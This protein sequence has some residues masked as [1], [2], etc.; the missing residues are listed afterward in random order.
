MRTPLLLLLASILASPALGAP[1]WKIADAPLRTPWADQVDPAKVLPEY[2]RPQMVRDRW[3]SLNGVWEFQEA[4]PTDALPSG[5]T[6]T[7]SIL[8]PFPWESALSGIRRQLASQRA[9]YRRTFEVP[10]AWRAESQR[11][12]LHFEAV[13][14]EATVFVNGRFAGQHHGGYDP[15]SFDI[16]PHL[17]P[18]GPQELIVTV[19]DPGNEQGIAAGKQANARFA[20][21]QRYSYAPSSGIW[22]PVWLEPVPSRYL[23]DYHVVP[24]IDSGR[25]EVTASP[26][27]QDGNLSVEVVARHG[28][29]VV[30][31]ASGSPN[32][33]ISVA[34]P[35]PRL[36][37]PHD[38]F[39]YD[40]DVVLQKGGVEVDR[41][42]GY[43][44][45]RKIA[46]GAAR[47]NSRG[48]V[49]K[50]FLNHRFMFQMGPLDQGFWP[51]GLH[52][53]PTDAALRW[54]VEGIKAWGFNMVRK[55]IKVESRRWFYHC[56]RAGLLV[57]QDMPSTFKQRTLEE[58]AQFEI[59]LARM[60]RTHWNHPSVVNWVVFNEHW[61]AYDVERLTN[62]VMALDPSRL[63]TGN[64]GI[65]AGKPH[66]DYQVGHI[67]DNHH[68]R[69]PTYPFAT[70]SRAA[71]NGEYGAIGYLVDGHVWDRDGPWVHY[72]YKGKED[73]TAEY[74]KFAA[75]LREFK[76][77]Q[78]L[79]GAVY[80]QWTDVENEM[81]GLHTYDRKVEKLDRARV[82]AA[83]RA[84]WVD[85][86]ASAPRSANTP[87]A[88]P[89][90]GGSEQTPDEGRK[91]R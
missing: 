52:T 79:S 64:S 28:A 72:N 48:P 27:A 50:L 26:D 1:P 75:Q 89:T 63:V 4:R 44:G 57:W 90:D 55:H 37:W 43:F 8:V 18:N 73:A 56:D 34:V 68:Y 33:P 24:D 82:T 71:V 41:V 29:Q 74:E 12:L 13:D 14:W 69:P 87:S 42:T 47:V 30:G 84:L 20:D 85:D 38:P 78:M 70:S 91:K 40:L 3:I 51:D 6:L 31:R 22:L 58:K 54:D 80:T 81:N 11:L 25:I 2:P 5:R 10:A 39:L 76:N 19:F 21:P 77:V 9:H 88:N 67:I 59:E 46:L 86:L 7:E 17:T 65:D 53:H 49:Q 23:A 45:M 62:F 35:A 15:F 32:L 83:N 66:F 60:V 16:T 61:G 36:W